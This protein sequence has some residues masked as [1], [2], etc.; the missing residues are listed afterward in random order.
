MT[1]IW[2][3]FFVFACD[4]SAVLLVCASVISH[5]AGDQQGG[6]N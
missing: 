6:V 3:Y 2:L 4:S 1:I 5:T